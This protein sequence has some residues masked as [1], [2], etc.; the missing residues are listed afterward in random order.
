MNSAHL[1]PGTVFAGFRVLRTLGEDQL[2]VVHAVEQLGAGQV[3]ALRVMHPH[4]A[5]DPNARAH[6]GQGVQPGTR[7]EQFTIGG[8]GAS[9]QEGTVPWLALELHGAEGLLSAGAFGA[10]TPTSNPGIGSTVA[11]SMPP[12]MPSGVPPM[13][14]G[15]PPPSGW[16]AGPPSNPGVS[17]TAFMSAMPSNPG[18]GPYG[19]PMGYPPQPSAPSSG[20][21]LIL[22]AAG[23]AVC[24]VLMVIGGAVLILRHKNNRDA[25]NES[26]TTTPALTPVPPPS[27]PYNYPPPPTPPTLGGGTPPSFAPVPQT[28]SPTA[29]PSMPPSPPVVRPS[30]PQPAGFACLGSWSG[31]ITETTGAYGSVGVVLTSL[32]GPSCG[33]WTERW[34]NSGHTC[35]YRFA[36]CRLVGSRLSG[37]GVATS[38]GCVPTVNAS[39]LCVGDRAVFREVAPNGVVDTAS[40]RRR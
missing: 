12:M 33:A 24:A 23:V 27:S 14:A 9:G 36:D 7:F 29:P 8:V 1:P 6:F 16:L 28:P 10:P 21:G 17:P 38:P 18:A 37:R 3:R 15:A 4:L 19:P 13:G 30:P 11:I 20:N 35:R 40:L 22:V 25:N 26:N 5:M 31:S 32:G 2:G 34:T 39:V